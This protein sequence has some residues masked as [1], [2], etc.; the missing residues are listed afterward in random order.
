[1]ILALLV[2]LL[3]QDVDPIRAKIWEFEKKLHDTADEKD[4]IPLVREFFAGLKDSATK[5]EAL[6]MLDSRYVYAIPNGI[7]SEIL[8]PLVRDADLAVRVRASRT[9]AYTGRGGEFVDE[10]LALVK[11]QTVGAKE[12][13]LWAMGQTGHE[14]FLAA[15]KQHLSHDNPVVRRAASTSLSRW[16]TTQTVHIARLLDDPDPEVRASAI[17]DLSQSGRHAFG[18]VR[19]ANDPDVRVRIAAAKALGEIGAEA[20]A[21]ARLL[22]DAHPSVRAEAARA[23]GQMRSL[24]HAAHVRKLLDDGDLQVRRYVIH[25]TGMLRDRESLP[26]LRELATDADDQTRTLAAQAIREITRP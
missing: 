7:E 23:L 25:A 2:A 8:A 19:L 3:A 9:L 15:I 5:I 22:G 6:G 10:L 18:I 4:R 11:E 1:M 13:A 24:E 21:V 17:Q 14:R 26:K 16:A 20:D 12:G